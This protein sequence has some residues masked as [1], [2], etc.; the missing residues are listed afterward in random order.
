MEP[1][2]VP[3]EVSLNAPGRDSVFFPQI[4]SGFRISW[5]VPEY[6]GGALGV[7]SEIGH[8]NGNSLF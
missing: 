5:S 2:Q 8:G 1:N 6:I 4:A 3:A 7:S